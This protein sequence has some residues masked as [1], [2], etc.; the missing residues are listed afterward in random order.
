LLYFDF[1]TVPTAD[2]L[3]WLP[4]VIKLSAMVAAP[5]WMLKEGKSDT[6][7]IDN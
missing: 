4:I 2:L 3:G 1:I 5:L 6:K 7:F